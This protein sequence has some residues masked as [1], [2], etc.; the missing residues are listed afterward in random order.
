M[1]ASIKDVACGKKKYKVEL[2]ITGEKQQFLLLIIKGVTI[3]GVVK[4]C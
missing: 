4:A 1:S 2:K 3:Y